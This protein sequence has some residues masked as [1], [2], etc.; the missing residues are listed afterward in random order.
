MTYITE[1][2]H[3]NGKFPEIKKCLKDF[4][5]TLRRYYN[6]DEKFEK[7]LTHYYSLDTLKKII[8]LTYNEF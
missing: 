5:M 4:F 7:F 8:S 2:Y 6:N 3:R 1:Q